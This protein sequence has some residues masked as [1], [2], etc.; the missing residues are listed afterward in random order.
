M[1]GLVIAMLQPNAT[2]TLNEVH[3]K[4]KEEARAAHCSCIGL[5]ARLAKVLRDDRLVLVDSNGDK[6]VRLRSTGAVPAKEPRVT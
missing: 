2:M 3:S 4:L 6:V 1:L 5:P